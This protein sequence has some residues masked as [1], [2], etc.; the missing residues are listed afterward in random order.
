M[1]VP[2]FHQR[3]SNTK[4]GLGQC[5]AA[6]VADCSWP[7]TRS[8]VVHVRVLPLGIYANHTEVTCGA[9][10]LVGY[11]SGNDNDIARTQV[12]NHTTLA[13]QLHPGRPAINPKH[14]VGGAVVVMD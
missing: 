4:I 12:M 2:L 13:S 1:P 7:F 10:I 5:N 8:S 3:A 11:A 14:F 9:E 6:D